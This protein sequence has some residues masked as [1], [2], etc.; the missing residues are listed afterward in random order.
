MPNLFFVDGSDK[1]HILNHIKETISLMEYPA[2]MQ[3]SIISRLAIVSFLRGK[4]VL[5]DTIDTQAI[6]VFKQLSSFASQNEEHGWFEEWSK[7][8]I[9]SV[10][11]RQIGVY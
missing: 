6:D 3:F 7:R 1:V 2:P 11:E 5:A 8:L 10:K 9:S 4:G